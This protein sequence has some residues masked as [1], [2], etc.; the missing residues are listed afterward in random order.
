MEKNNTIDLIYFVKKWKVLLC[1][2][3][4]FGFM[5][6]LY[7]SLFSTPTYWCSRAYAVN[8]GVFYSNDDYNKQASMND[9]T[10]SRSLVETYQ[11][12]LSLPG[13]MQ[14]LADN[15]KTQ[16][17]VDVSSSYLSSC[18]RVSTS[19]STEILNITVKTGDVVL[20]RT[21]SDSV[22]TFLVPYVSDCIGS[23]EIRSLGRLTD[24]TS[25]ASP[26]KMGILGV[27]VG[28]A[29]ALAALLLLYVVNNK[30]STEE[31]FLKRT[32]VLI[33]GSIPDPHFISKGGYR[34]GE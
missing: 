6:Y 22:D 15:I 13:M 30:V 9:I 27:F 3:L 23:A 20:S 5:F 7:T 10:V 34:Y 25:I 14:E 8:N 33:L 32:N 4:V 11:A 31:E 29:A 26:I 21:I 28:I 17:G 19:G 1:V 16:Y 2:G 12:A 18:I 24:G